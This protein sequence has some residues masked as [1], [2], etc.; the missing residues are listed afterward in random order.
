[1]A[2]FY[3]ETRVQRISFNRKSF[4]SKYSEIMKC[5]TALKVSS[6]WSSRISIDRHKNYFKSQNFATIHIRKLFFLESHFS[7]RQSI[8]VFQSGCLIYDSLLS[9]VKHYMHIKYDMLLI[10]YYKC[11]DFWFSDWLT[12]KYEISK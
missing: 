4:L 11:V 10:T 7:N 1:M 9:S 8:L 5:L 3:Y 12:T 6:L 2:K